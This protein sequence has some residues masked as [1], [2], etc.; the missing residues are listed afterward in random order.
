MNDLNTRIVP[1]CQIIRQR[2]AALRLT[3][4]Q[5]AA[6]LRVEPATVGLWENGRRRMELDKIPR[7]A[8]ILQ[9]NEADLCRRALWEWHP[10]LHASLFGPQPPRVTSG[11]VPRAAAGLLEA[12]VIVGG[13]LRQAEE[14]G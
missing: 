11:T 6:E 13:R 12:P 1:L 14:L 9:L 2:R 5:V 10:R 7:L 8:A 4:A 3:Q